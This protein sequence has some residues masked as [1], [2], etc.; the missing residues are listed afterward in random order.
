MMN[1]HDKKTAIIVSV[2]LVC[3]TAVAIAMIA[4]R[5]RYRAI[6]NGSESRHKV[7]DTRTGIIYPDGIPENE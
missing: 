3:A 5:P 6:W 7:L 4:R 2:A 1:S